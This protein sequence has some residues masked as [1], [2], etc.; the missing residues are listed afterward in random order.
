M[1][2]PPDLNEMA[3]RVIDTNHYMI[4]GTQDPDG[5]PRL[6][7]VFYTAARYTDLYWLSW[8]DA[9]HSRNVAER[10]EVQVVILDSTAPV[11]AGEAVYL[12]AEV[13]TIADGEL[14]AVCD[15]AFRETAGAHRFTRACATPR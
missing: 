12:A 6:S 15:E 7:P 5:R 11:G 9:Q 1:T 13:R 2:L 8:P 4:L 3:R 10:P 14:E